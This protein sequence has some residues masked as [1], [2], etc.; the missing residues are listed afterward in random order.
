MNTTAA[1]LDRISG[2]FFT[3]GFFI[4]R[5]RI[6]PI[7]LLNAVLNIVSLLSYLVGYVAW[8]AAT[9]LYPNHP[10]KRDAWY[11]FAEFKD[12]FQVASIL[13]TAATIICLTYPPLLLP[14]LWLFATSNF[15]WI[16]GEY[17]RKENPPPYDPNF[18]TP[19]QET[20][21]KYAY[22]MTSIS[23]LTAAASTTA[24]C[25]P[26]AAPMVLLSSTVIG[27]VMTVIAFNYWRQSAYGEYKPDR[28]RH[29][30]AHL[31]EGLDFSLAARPQHEQQ[32][33]L[34]SDHYDNPTQKP[35]RNIR[36]NPSVPDPTLRDETL[37]FC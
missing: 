11:G 4:S 7:A 26:L 31:A 13:G 2:Y 12:Q 24:M 37:S 6:L 21:L 3:A 19:R 23:L 22:L 16:V 9:L 14:A 25:F 34:Q 20:Y 10:R 27:T 33:V 1:R 29:S 8:F 36:S 30:Y 5:A 28:V 18:S 32:D 35:V 17:H 15:L